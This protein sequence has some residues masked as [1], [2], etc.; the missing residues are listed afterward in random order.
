MWI[1]SSSTSLLPEVETIYY[2][3]LDLYR[4]FIGRDDQSV[5]EKNMI[6]RI[7]AQQ[8]NTHTL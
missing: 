5:N 8:L 2:L 4:Y 3:N 1:T 6:K 7:Q